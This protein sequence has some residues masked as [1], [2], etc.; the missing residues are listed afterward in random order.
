MQ[1]ERL[2]RFFCYYLVQPFV[3]ILIAAPLITSNVIVYQAEDL[4]FTE[5]VK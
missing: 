1:R 4:F 5:E 2:L 3:F